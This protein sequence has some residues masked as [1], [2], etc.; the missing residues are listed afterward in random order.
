MEQAVRDALQR[1][2]Q[3]IERRGQF[4]S[5]WEE[6]AEVLAPHRMGFTSTWVPGQHRSAKQFDTAPA[7]A[8]RGLASAIDGLIKPK[9]AQWFEIDVEGVDEEVARWLHEVERIQ[10][11]AMYN[12][13]AR[14]QQAT[15][16]ADFDL[17]NFGNA[18]VMVTESFTRRHL[19]YRCPHLK[20][21]YFLESAD[22]GIDT[23]H[24]SERLSARE[25]AQRW[26]E[27]N[28][29]EKARK[30][31]ADNRPTERGTYISMIEPRRDR[32]PRRSDAMNMPFRFMVIDK[33]SGHK[34]VESGFQEFPAAVPRWD[35]TTGEVYGRGPG[36]MALPDVQTVQQ[37]KKTLLKAGHRA[38][39]PPWL[40]P[41]NGLVGAMQNWPGGIT[42]Y[43]AVEVA[44]S[45][46]ADPLRQLDSRAN[47]PFGLDLLQAEREEIAR[48]FFRGVLNLPQDGPEMTATEVIQRQQEFIREIGAVFGRLETDYIAPIVERTFNILLRRSAANNW[49]GPFP[50]PPASLQGRDVEFKFT[51]PITRAKQQI[52][53]A[54]VQQFIARVFGLAQADPSALDSID[55]DAAI[56][57]DAEANDIQPTILRPPEAVQQLRQQRAQQVQAQEQAAQVQ[58]AADIGKTTAEA[59]SKATEAV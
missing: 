14:F 41:A 18:T 6:V 22:G 2:D 59:V 12:P 27:E 21:C 52:E 20:D 46:M 34:V 40:A 35:T 25:A 51:S 5:L 33:D 50:Q 24:I 8:A 9:Q 48:V 37:I 7:E 43:N 47:V 29:G 17:V 1:H 10:W 56:R 11:R 57:F 54:Q 19:L 28:L 32:D 36:T 4:P 45:G 44:K 23:L 42:F 26:G 30:A 13:A 55:I 58:Q 15:G 53:S 3:A 39:D 16:E 49:Q 31:L 38:V